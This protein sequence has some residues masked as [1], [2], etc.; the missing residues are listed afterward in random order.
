MGY[1]KARKVLPKELLEM[2]QEYVDGEY[3]YIPR[4]ED[5]KKSWG[6]ST[7]IR[8]ELRIRNEQICSDYDSGC[9]MHEL[10]KKYY[11]S[12]KSIQRIVRQRKSDY[13]L[14]SRHV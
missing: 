12:V 13:N 3:L 4:K 1:R 11:L 10:A 2:I 6:S 9:S 14:M 7:D 8:V 5:T